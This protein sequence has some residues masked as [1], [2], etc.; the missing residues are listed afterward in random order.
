MKTALKHLSLAAAVSAAVV[1]TQAFA[2]QAGDFFVRTG[3]ATVA[4]DESSDGLAV[5][6]L[7]GVNGFDGAAELGGTGV[8]VDDDTQLGL[9]VTYMMSESLG[10]E[11]LAATPFTHDITAD[12]GGLGKVNAGET[13]H[14]PPTLS[15]VWYPMGTSG[16]FKP[17]LGAGINYTIFFEEEVSSDLEAGLSPVADAITGVSVGLPSPMPLDLELEDSVG[18][19]F[20]A[21]VDV[22]LDDKWHLNASVRWIDI[23]TEAKIK[24]SGTT[25]IEIDNIEIDPLV[26]QINL[27][28]KF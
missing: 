4:P 22:A 10:V 14:L 17:Y 5:P 1:S 6:A 18:L 24:S 25:I 8:E 21:G 13:T 23:D 7:D 16:Q 12:L 26:Y 28:Y 15:L 20:Q 3:A 19:A 9:T 2:Y 11:L 27:G